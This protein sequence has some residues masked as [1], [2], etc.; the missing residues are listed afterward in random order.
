MKPKTDMWLNSNMAWY[1]H[2]MSQIGQREQT[3][4]IRYQTWMTQDQYSAAHE[5][6]LKP[7][8]PQLQKGVL[9]KLNTDFK[10]KVQ[11]AEEMQEEN[12]PP[13]LTGRQI[14]F[15]IYAFFKINDAQGRASGMNDLLNVELRKTVDGG[16]A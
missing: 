7:W 11:V 5:C 12:G 16:R 10:R 14:A 13:M 4:R 2:T 8:I 3:K 6:S 9:K 1:T 15:M